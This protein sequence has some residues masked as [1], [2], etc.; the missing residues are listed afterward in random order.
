MYKIWSMIRKMA[1]ANSLMERIGKACELTQQM[2]EIMGAAEQASASP[3]HLPWQVCQQQMNNT[4]EEMEESI[5]TL[6][7]LKNVNIP[8]EL[9]TSID[10]IVSNAKLV[11]SKLAAQEMWESGAAPNAAANPTEYV[12]AINSYYKEAL[13]LISQMIVDCNDLNNMVQMNASMEVRGGRKRKRRTHRNRR[14][15]THRKRTYRK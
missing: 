4:R 15:R 8:G 11:H 6:K 2:K 13:H 14:K 7:S 3:Y 9:K 10:R 5:Q 12:Q 1:A